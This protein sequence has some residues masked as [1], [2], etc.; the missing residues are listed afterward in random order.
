MKEDG[1]NMM[2][3]VASDEIT[4]DSV[5]LSSFPSVSKQGTTILSDLYENNVNYYGPA[6]Q[7][8]YLLITEWAHCIMGSFDL[9]TKKTVQKL[10]SL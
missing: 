6:I 7:D 9:L 2:E 4:R 3:C 8:R 10:F 1:Q 5:I